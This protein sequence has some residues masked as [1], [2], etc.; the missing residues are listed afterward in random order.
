MSYQRVRLYSPVHDC[1]VV[2]VSM[3]DEHGG[4]LFINVVD[5]RGFKALRNSIY[6]HT[7]GEHYFP[8]ALD[9]LERA[10]ER[11]DQ[12]GEVAFDPLAQSEEILYQ[13][14]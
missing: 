7:V 12:P 8:G 6:G 3:F 10:L 1:Y 13:P 14:G 2:R 11:E 4:E 9:T 5:N